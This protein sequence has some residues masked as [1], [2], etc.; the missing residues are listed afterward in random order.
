MKEVASAVVRFLGML[1]L[2]INSIAELIDQGSYDTDQATVDNWLH[3]SIEYRD[4][5]RATGQPAHLLQGL[6]EA[7]DHAR[8]AGR[9][10]DGMAALFPALRGTGHEA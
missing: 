10:A 9:S 5:V 6:V 4:I 3:S 7:L 8:S 2:E 1:E